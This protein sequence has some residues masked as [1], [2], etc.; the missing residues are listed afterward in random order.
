MKLGSF[1]ECDAGGEGGSDGGDYNE[2]L[3]GGVVMVM[4]M[5]GYN[6]G[7]GG[8]IES[9]YVNGVG[10]GCTCQEVSQSHPNPF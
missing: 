9:S 2:K 7:V 5:M 6:D 1:N 8:G 10:S 4:M 3:V